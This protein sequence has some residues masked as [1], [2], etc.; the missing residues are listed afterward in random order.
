MRSARF[1]AATAV[2]VL[3]FLGVDGAAG[4]KGGARPKIF[5]TDV[6]HDLALASGEPEI[7]VDPTDPRNLAIVEFALGSKKYPADRIN[8]PMQANGEEAVEAMANDGRVMLSHDGGD[9]WHAHPPPAHDPN[10]AGGGDPM[11][12]YGP[13]GALYVADEPFPKQ[14]AMRG[15]MDHYRFVIA[16]STDGGKTF[17]E[18]QQVVTPIDRPFLVV[19]QSTGMVYTASTGYFDAQTGARNQ[20]IPGAIFDRWLVAWQPHLTA[21]SRPRRMGGPD[22]SAASGSTMTAANGVIASVFII[23]SP[24]ADMFGPAVTQSVPVPPSLRPLVTDGRTSC[25]LQSPCL[26]FQTSADQ[27]RHWTRHYVPVPGGFS[28]LFAYVSADPGRPGRYAIGVLN[29]D[30]TGLRVLLTDDS[31]ATWSKPIAVPG[32]PGAPSIPGRPLDAKHFQLFSLIN[33]GSILRPWMAY[34]PTGVL[35]FMWRQRRPALAGS[36][37]QSSTPGASWGAGY[38]VYA[39]ISCDGGRRWSPP[40]K[41]NSEPS[42]AGSTAFDD[43]SYMALDAHYAH[44]VWGDRRMMAKVKNASRLTRGGIQVFYARVPFSVVSKGAACGRP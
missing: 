44:V 37:P 33:R 40:V 2:A 22:F 32:V 18:P 3:S 7:A 8:P 14:L 27:G 25:Q 12:A 4:A 20:H 43:L 26:F 28:G 1:V 24:A 29:A 23:G 35:G 30:A 6:T 13:D 41:V 17:R 42:P 15:T 21:H 9:T 34:G 10:K 31:G 36:P 11:I 38:D 16:V 39:A 5:E 19:D